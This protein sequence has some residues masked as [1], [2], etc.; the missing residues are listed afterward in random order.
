MKLGIALGGGGMKGMAHVGALRIFQAGRVEFEVVVGT[1]AGAIAGALYA[2]G[3]SADEMEAIIRTTPLRQWFGRDRTGMGFFSTD[4]IRRVFESILGKDARIENLPRRFACVTVDLETQSE[5]VFESGSVVDAVCASA[6]YPGLFAPV[7]IQNHY[8]IDGGALNPL[9][10]DVAR[11]LGSEYVVAVDLWSPE[12]FTMPQPPR[13]GLLWQ[14]FNSMPNAKIF[15]VVDRSIAVMMLGLRNAKMNVA[16]PDVLLTPKLQ[17]VGMIDFDRIDV[18]MAEGEA[19]ARDA[20]DQIKREAR[21]P[22]WW[23]RS[24]KL[25]NAKRG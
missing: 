16:P 23:Y 13:Q 10:F 18:A 8:Y 21:L 5:V 3:K 6:A 9:P 19:V 1:S 25:L 24:Q 2:A 15:R 17:N 22:R 7:C 20:L 12:P 4:G 14:L 11:R